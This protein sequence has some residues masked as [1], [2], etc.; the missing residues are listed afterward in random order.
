MIARQNYKDCNDEIFALK[1]YPEILILIS[2]H[3]ENFVTTKYKYLK[4]TILRF[5]RKSLYLKRRYK[6]YILEK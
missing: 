3:K 4:K 6:N 5:G 1:Y 2:F